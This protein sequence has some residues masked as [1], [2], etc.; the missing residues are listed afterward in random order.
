M[1]P[2]D[3]AELGL[4]LKMKGKRPPQSYLE[5]SSSFRESSYHSD[6]QAELQSPPPTCE[7]LPT[8]VGRGGGGGGGGGGEW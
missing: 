3:V 7:W 8:E 4:D 1:S 6:I 5:Y 2:E